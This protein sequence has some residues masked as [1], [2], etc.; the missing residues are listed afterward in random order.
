MKRLG[1][2]IL[3]CGII[4]AIGSVILGSTDP[5]NIPTE[6]LTTQR[7]IESAKKG[8]PIEAGWVKSERGR[9]IFLSRNPKPYFDQY[10]DAIRGTGK[11]KVSLPFK[12][13]EQVTGKPLEPHT[14]ETGDC[15]AHAFGLSI[16]ILAAT[17]IVYRQSPQRWVAPTATEIIYAGGRVESGKKYGFSTR[18]PGMY[19]YLASDW[20]KT[21]GVLLRQKYPGGSDFTEYSGKVA[22]RLG[23]TGVPNELEPLAKLHLVGNVVLVKSYEEVRDAIANGFPVVICSSQGFITKGGRDKDGFLAPSTSP[24]MHS[25][26]VIGVDDKSDRKGCLIQNSWGSNWISGPVRHG[27]PVGSFWVDCAV[28]DR[29]VKMGDSMAISSYAGYPRQDI[30]LW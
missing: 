24:W 21:G 11:D 12:F 6:P 16:D 30:I 25:M 13:L 8:T 26:A 10:D 14:Q 27:Q 1:C 9:V 3:I 22:D 18:S 23:R 19:G 29:M 28:I 17:Q 5:I 2:L 15:V 7:F 4:L 20:V